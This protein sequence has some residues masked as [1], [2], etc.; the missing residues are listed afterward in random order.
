LSLSSTEVIVR[1]PRISLRYAASGS[2][3]AV[4]TEGCPLIRLHVVKTRTIGDVLGGFCQPEMMLVRGQEVS[5]VF[6]ATK[7]PVAAHFG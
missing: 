7:P 4:M 3:P 6:T 1:K 2:K 5:T